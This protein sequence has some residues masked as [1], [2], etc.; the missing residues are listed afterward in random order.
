M[1][2]HCPDFVLTIQPEHKVTFYDNFVEIMFCQKFLEQQQKRFILTG[3]RA[4]NPSMITLL[5]YC[6]VKHLS[7]NENKIYLYRQLCSQSFYD[8][9]VEILIC[10]TSLEQRKQD[11]SLQAVVLT[12][13][14]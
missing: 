12:I 14:L 8:S 5:K 2:Q 4:H 11:L 6:S 3:S 10:K 13:L 1:D 9:F 7:N